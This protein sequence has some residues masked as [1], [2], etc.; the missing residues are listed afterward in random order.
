MATKADIRYVNET[1]SEFQELGDLKA[2]FYELESLLHGKV[3][4]SELDE[5]M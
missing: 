3:N 5:A 1:I 4:R 2:Q